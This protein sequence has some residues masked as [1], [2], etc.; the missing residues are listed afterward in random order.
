MD[1]TKISK[2]LA[3]HG[4]IAAIWHID[5]V[6]E[7]RPDLSKAQCMKVLLACERHHDAEIGIN[8]DVLRFW[9]EELPAG[10]EP[11]A[12]TDGIRAAGRGPRHDDTPAGIIAGLEHIIER[13]DAEFDEQRHRL[14]EA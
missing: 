12:R 13:M 5:D 10:A 4:Y 3:A 14:V 6:R 8:W 11:P 2:R 9:A 7:L 1:T